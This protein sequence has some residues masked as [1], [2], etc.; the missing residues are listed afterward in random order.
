MNEFKII[1]K[2]LGVFVLIVMFRLCKSKSASLDLET[3]GFAV[4]GCADSAG[5]SLRNAPNDSGPNRF[6][7]V[8]GYILTITGKFNILYFKNNV[9]FSNWVCSGYPCR[10]PC[11]GMALCLWRISG[12]SI[13]SLRDSQVWIDCMKRI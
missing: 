8:C 6:T 4:C 1:I 7:G 11:H 2:V 13:A 12:V 9:L 3:V 10:H 5:E